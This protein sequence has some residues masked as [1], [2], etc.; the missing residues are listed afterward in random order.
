AEGRAQQRRPNRAKEGRRLH[1]EAYGAGLGSR[2]GG[3][4]HPPRS[5][6]WRRRD[7]RDRR[8][9]HGAATAA[10]TTA[11]RALGPRLLRRAR[12]P[13]LLLTG[14]AAGRRAGCGDWGPGP[15]S[16]GF[17]RSGVAVTEP[18]PR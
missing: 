15:E 1:E 4:L 8:G 3:M 12:L 17:R 14:S 10:A 2:F 16:P 5:S 11:L 6:C 7:R 13:R 9:Q 18:T